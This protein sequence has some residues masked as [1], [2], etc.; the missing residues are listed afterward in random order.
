MEIEDYVETL[1]RI[2]ADPS[3][4]AHVLVGKL[5][6]LGLR[7]GDKTLREAVRQYRAPVTSPEGWVTRAEA[8][9]ELGLSIQRVDQLRR[10]G[11]LVWK[12]PTGRQGVLVSLTS[13][14]CYKLQRAGLVTEP[15]VD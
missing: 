8:A 9:A 7:A 11:A 14:R 4:P 3:L 12:S 6:S 1:R 10:E 2:N 15:C 13:V 5:R